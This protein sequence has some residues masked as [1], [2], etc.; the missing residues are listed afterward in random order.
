MFIGGG[1]EAHLPAASVTLFYGFAQLATGTET[2]DFTRGNRHGFPG[3]RVAAFAGFPMGDGEGAKAD[4]GHRRALGEG[5]ADGFNEAVHSFLG[6]GFVQASAFG[7]LSNEV[8]FCHFLGFTGHGVLLSRRGR[9][10]QI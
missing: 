5:G 2:N 9:L 8:G 10:W 6:L 1:E 3:S 7:D 4:E